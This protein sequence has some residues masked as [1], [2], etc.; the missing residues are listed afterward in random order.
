MIGPQC[1]F[2][3]LDEESNMILEEYDRLTPS[4]RDG[5]L[6]THRRWKDD[7]HYTYHG[8]KV[9]FCTDLDVPPRLSVRQDWIDGY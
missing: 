7:D 3:V 8:K 5:F 6:E 4:E 2:V 9:V 1:Y